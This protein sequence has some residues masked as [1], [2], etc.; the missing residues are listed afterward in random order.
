MVASSTRRATFIAS[1]I[2]VTRQY[3]F[4]GVDIGESRTPSS[5][6]PD[7]DKRETHESRDWI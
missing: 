3:N 6:H 4:D 5:H 1:L 2:S 7:R